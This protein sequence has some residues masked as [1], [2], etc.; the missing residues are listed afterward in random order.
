MSPYNH[1]FMAPEVRVESLD[2]LAEGL[3]EEVR[4]AVAVLLKAAAKVQGEVLND[5]NRDAGMHEAFIAI[6]MLAEDLAAR[7]NSGLADRTREEAEAEKYR[8]LAEGFEL[9]QGKR[10]RMHSAMI[11]RGEGLVRLELKRIFSLAE[12]GKVRLELM[13]DEHRLSGAVTVETL[14]EVEVMV[15]VDPETKTVCFIVNPGDLPDSPQAR[16]LIAKEFKTVGASKDERKYKK[17]KKFAPNQLLAQ[18]EAGNIT[19]LNKSFGDENDRADE[20]LR[21]CTAGEGVSFT[22]LITEADA[23]AKIEIYLTPGGQN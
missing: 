20:V 22:C 21:L 1:F 10:G 7:V 9:L 12:E 16:L 17:L 13:G 6:D 18:R 11:D 5:G 8:L 14:D 23:D 19:I 4:S 15:Q 2:A 3:T